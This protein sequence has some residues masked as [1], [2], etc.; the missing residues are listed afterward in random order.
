MCSFLITNIKQI[1]KDLNHLNRKLQYRGPDRTTMLQIKYKQQQLTFLHNLLS[2]TGSSNNKKNQPFTNADQSIIAIYNGEIYNYKEFISN[3]P[4]QTYMMGNNQISDGECLIP[5]YL[6]YGPTFT[7]KLYGEFAI[8]LFDL[9]RDIMIISSDIFAT[10]PMYLSFKDGNFGISSYQYAL[11]EMGFKDNYKMQE[12]TIL[13]VS[14]QSHEFKYLGKVYEFQLNQYKTNFNDWN[15]AFN[16]ALK[17]R[18]ENLK[19]GVAVTLSSGYDSGTLCCALSQNNIKH[20]TFS[21]LTQSENNVLIYSRSNFRSYNQI[22]HLFQLNNLNREKLRQEIHQKIDKFT[23]FV[24]RAKTKSYSILTDDATLGM[25]FM[26]QKLR[27]NNC[28][29]HLS[30]QGADEIF[31]DYGFNG[32]KFKSHSC[33]GGKFPDN[34]QD[35]FPWFS[36]YKGTQECFLMKEE[37]VAGCYGIENR[38]PYLDRDVV[39]EFLWLSPQLKNNNYKAPL[40]NYMQ[41][42]SY[43]FDLNKKSGFSCIT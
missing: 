37:Y 6:K 8:I 5:A 18:T 33:F 43:P 40:H 34:L 42:Y 21:C 20:H 14:L 19:T 12:N 29:V 41:Q 15:K 13:M 16:R 10:K 24:D 28:L 7:Q 27:E 26:Y 32:I 39:Q 38:Y 3:N 2:I 23:S 35:I 11:E 1:E 17:L 36:F 9:N 4:N 30:G 25:G 31:A 22:A